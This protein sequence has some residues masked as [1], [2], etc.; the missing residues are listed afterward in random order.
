MVTALIAIVAALL[1]FVPAAGVSAH[2]VLDNSVPA[3]GATLVD[4]PP[5]I[6]LDFDEPVETALGFIRLFASDGSRI[7]LPSIQRDASD[8]SI[9]RV[10][11]PTLDDDTYVVTYRVISLD[12][13]PVDGA[14]TFQVGEGEKA[15]VSD[16]L[17]GALGDVDD[18]GTVDA[19]ARVVRLIGHIALA[20]VLAGGLFLLGGPVSATFRVRLAGVVAGAATVVALA[21]AGTLGLHAATLTGGGLG[22]AVRWSAIGEVSDTRVGHALIVRLVLAVV[23]AVVFGVAAALSTRPGSDGAHPALASTPVRFLAVLGFIVFPLSY[24]YAGHAGAAG[25]VAVVASVL[26][27]AS[28]AAWFGGLV[29]MGVFAAMRDEATVKWFS[30][31][32]AG[33]IV[34]AV[35]GGVVQAVLIVD[36]VTGIL[37]IAYGRAL[38]TKLV[39][40]AIMLLAAAVVRRRFLDS[41]AARL[42]SVIVVEAV[43]GLLVLGATT[44]LVTET[45]RSTVSAAPFATT[46]VQGETILNVTVSPA[47]VGAVEMHVI[48]SKPGGSLEPVESARVRFASNANDVPPITVE[49]AEVGPNHFVANAQIPFAG[50]WRI[51]VV[52][53]EPEG[54]ETLFSTTFEARP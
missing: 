45:P 53:L 6:V 23:A 49:P 26:H 46:L 32:A 25:F 51:D 50:E 31:R 11:A 9:V 12:G 39:L 42:R 15:D 43:V 38:A 5:Q 37:D 18:N 30:Q 19:V 44:G 29:L 48:V 41:G 20:L 17:A 33:M 24:S 14:I 4:S 27:V 35:V 40:V 16:V 47:R 52:L 13:H 21:A 36:D 3:S 1:V 2:A 8:D 22:D 54:R 34:I 28:V 7:G 10:D